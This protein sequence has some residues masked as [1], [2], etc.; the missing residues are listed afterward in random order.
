MVLE[1][2]AQWIDTVVNHLDEFYKR[3]DD[4]IQK[5]QQELKASKKK[6]ELETKLAQEMK[7]HNE[8]TERLAELSRRGTELDRVCASMGRVTIADN[9]KSRLDNA[10]E[11]YQLAKELTGIR[12]NFSAP[13]DIAKGYIRSESRKLLQPFE[14]DMSAGGDSED[15]WAVIQSTAAPGWNFLNDKENRP[16]N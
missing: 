14:I 10:K 13:T 8:L 12:L 2:N 7:L 3:V 1:S 16:N 5:E 4:K 11:N 15:L 9:D 6:T